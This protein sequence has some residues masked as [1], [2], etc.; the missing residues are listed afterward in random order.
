MTTLTIDGLEALLGR[1][2]L[3]IP[4][5]HFLA[6]DVLNK[7][8]DIGR[9]YL[10]DILCS[11]VESDTVNAYGSVTLPSDIYNGDLAVILPKLQHG[12]DP[13][14]L[15]FD[16]MQRVWHF[17]LM[18]LYPCPLFALPFPEGVHLRIMFMPQMLGRLLFPYI[19]DRKDSY[20]RDVSLGLLNT[21]SPELG[22]KK[23]VVEFSSP[24]I[25]SE[26]QGKHLRSTILGA[27]ISNLYV[28]M[29]WDVVKINYLGD[30]GK[31]IGLL[32]VGWEKFGSEELFQT[33]PAGHLFN[34]YHKIND[35]FIPEQLASKKARDDGK[36][37]A[38]IETQGLFAERNAF[39]KRMEY[40]DETA[41]ALWKRVRDVNVENYTELYARLNVNFD[42]YSGESQVNPETMAEVE[43]TLKSKGLCEESGGS[44]II[45]LKKH[46]GKAGAV[47][48]RDRT[49]SSTYLLRDLAA[50]LDRAR[51]HSFDKMIYV[52]AADQH[53]T[54]FSRL[55]RILELM[56]MS[57]LAS[58]L[59]HVHF[60][61]VSQMSK[62]LG[63]GHM[64]GEI[65]DQCQSAMQ[66]SLN[67][68]PEKAGLLGN[69][70]EAVASIGI[71]ALLAQELSARRAN[72]HAFDISQMTSFEPGTG[73]DLQYWYAK[74]C[75]ILKTNPAQM[76]FSDAEFASLK[77]EDH[78]SLLRLLVQ[79]P[80]VTFSAYKSLES[81]TVMTYLVNITGQLSLCFRESEVGTSLTPAQAMLYAATRIVLENGMK[82]LGITPAAKC[83]SSS[84]SVVLIC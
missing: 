10:A 40:G 50:V 27:Y 7:P 74:L 20:G 2:G 63:H 77:D 9:S 28:T 37:P 70:E 44:W 46:T 52:T 8:L 18:S 54:H 31:P 21:S 34:V 16:L 39:F 49:G 24:N 12:A 82:L 57:D 67:A 11:L 41:M 45:D 38:E 76:D 35:L 73:P 4:I 13:N 80:D 71:S 68:N 6:A 51:K 72:D 5:P 14:V 69:T 65:L 61:D 22:R 3:K 66:G 55:F 25:A 43:E 15:A 59:Q 33:D 23:L 30:W 79:Y 1:L 60:S 17:S 78:T 64:L 32:G 48:I 62:K 56:D 42:E 19:N 58:K 53:T 47:I 83:A 75:S 29:G 26:F 36:D 81:A 84:S